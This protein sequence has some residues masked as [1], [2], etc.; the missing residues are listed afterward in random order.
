[1]AVLTIT[2]ANVEQAS[3]KRPVVYTA[4]EAI[5]AGAVVFQDSTTAKVGLADNTVEAEA[6]A[7]G[8]AITNCSADGDYIVVAPDGAE[9]VSGGTMVA[10]T[11]YHLGAQGALQLNSDN[12]STEYVT[13]VLRATSTTNGIITLDVTGVQIA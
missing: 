12:I 4:S 5:T 2:A 8:I 13:G 9:I 11:Y 7:I 10:G 6:V 1:M 3:T